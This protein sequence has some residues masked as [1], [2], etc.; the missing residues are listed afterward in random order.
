MR[1]KSRANRTLQRVHTPEAAR[2]AAKESLDPIT[3][4]TD[5]T[6]FIN[7]GRLGIPPNV[8]DAT[9]AAVQRRHGA[10]S[11]F[12]AKEDPAKA[13]S[14]ISRIELRY[15]PEAFVLH[16]VRHS[17][18]FHADIKKQLGA[19]LADTA[20]GSL[21]IVKLPAAKTH[22]EWV[23]FDYLARSGTQASLD[24]FHLAPSALARFVQGQGTGEIQVIPKIRVL[25]TIHE[26]ARLLDEA[27]A[28]A[29]EVR[30]TLPEQMLPRK[31]LDDLVRE[32]V[33]EEAERN[34]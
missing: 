22:S 32:E 30:Q 5:G 8:Y 1:R 13:D 10:V 19:W 25:T 3:I 20:R 33:D 29:Q 2:S 34:V 14:L 15:P 11:I 16:F 9:F 12:F 7:T 21:D 17:R 27:T 26:L 18:K 31:S 28:V 24:F 23:N 6:V 4:G